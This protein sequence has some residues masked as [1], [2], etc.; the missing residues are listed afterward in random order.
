M[1]DEHVFVVGAGNSAG[2][3]AVHLAH[4]AAQVTLIGRGTGLTRHHVGRPEGTR[5]AGRR[6]G[7]TRTVRAVALFVLGA[8]PQT[9]R[10][11]ASIARDDK[12]FILTGQD[13]PSSTRRNPAL[14]S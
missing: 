7:R 14:P 3:A 10:L 1:A 6:S 9:D 4:D 12:E 5:A 11:P 8:E 2:R 13:A